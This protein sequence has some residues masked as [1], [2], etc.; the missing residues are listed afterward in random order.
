MPKRRLYFLRNGPWSGA[1]TLGVIEELTSKNTTTLALDEPDLRTLAALKV[2]LDEASVDLPAWL[3]LRRPA[4]GITDLPAGHERIA[5]LSESS[6]P[7]VPSR[8]GRRPPGQRDRRIGPPTLTVG[9]DHTTGEPVR[10]ALESLRKHVAIFAGSG[11][12]KTVLIRRLVEE[13]ALQGVSAIVLDPNND[14]ARLGDPWP[15]T[16]DGLGT[17]RRGEGRRLPRRHRG[18]GV[19][20]EAR[21]PGGR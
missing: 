10:L 16:A 21:R 11:S 6:A 8:V 1:K 19:D 5:A 20:A 9:H 14:L 2:M 17:R 18:R 3:T 7:I 12:G 4:S 13:C 15:A